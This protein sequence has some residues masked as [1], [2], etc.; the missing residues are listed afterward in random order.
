M[1]GGVP[2]MSS[3]GPEP[4]EPAPRGETDAAS[5]SHGE[6]GRPGRAMRRTH[7]LLGED[8]TTLRRLLAVALNRAGYAVTEAADSESLLDYVTRAL[9]V[10]GR[11]PHPDLI[12]TDVCMPGLTGL[13]V[14]AAITRAGCI[15]PLIVMT[16]FGDRATR[17]RARRLGAV[18]VLD[19]PFDV[20][21]LVSL[22]RRTVPPVAP[23][24]P[25][26]S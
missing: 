3:F 4:P 21:D 17:E 8:D 11:V 2:S 12:I 24:A 16:A 19:K 26:S 15:T 1:D 10:P 7:V 9:L 13:D 6:P 14:A 20:D 23:G 5:R 22:A 25:R 18:A